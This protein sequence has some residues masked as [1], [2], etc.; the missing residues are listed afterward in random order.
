MTGYGDTN[1]LRV[2]NSHKTW[3]PPDIALCCVRWEVE[4]TSN[5]REVCLCC[6]TSARLM[7]LL[8]SQTVYL[9][10]SPGLPVDYPSRRKM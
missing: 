8:F 2:D 10:M 9:V 3:R 1:R 4:S 6:R 5:N 7:L